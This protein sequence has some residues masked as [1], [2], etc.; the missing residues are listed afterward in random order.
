[1]TDRQQKTF[2][3]A[4]FSLAVSVAGL[5]ITIGIGIAK[6][7]TIYGIMSSEHQ[8]LFRFDQQVLEQNQQMIK[9]LRQLAQEIHESRERIPP[10]DKR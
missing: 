4:I 6:I 1:M 2:N 7:G 10:N 5:A 8:Q 3:T 9:E